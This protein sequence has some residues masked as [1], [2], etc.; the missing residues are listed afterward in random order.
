[1]AGSGRTDEFRPRVDRRRSG[2]PGAR[3]G[4]KSRARADAR[5]LARSAGGRCEV[6]YRARRA[7]CC[8]RIHDGTISFM[9]QAQTATQ[10]T[11]A[12][13]AEKIRSRTARVGVVGLGYVGLP[14]AVEFAKAGFH[15]T[16]ID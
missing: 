13:L 7:R 5:R 14:L 6:P 10:L 16:G 11:A 12:V 9:S 2:G 3:N 15:V 1:W 8:R 4:Q